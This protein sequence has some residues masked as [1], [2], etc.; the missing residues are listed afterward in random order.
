MP[1]TLPVPEA[2][3]LWPE[4]AIGH[5]YQRT[6]VNL[7]DDGLPSKR[8]SRQ[9]GASSSIAHMRQPLA[10][11]Q[12]DKLVQIT[13]SRLIT[14]A[15]ASVYD[16]QISEADVRDVLSRGWLRNAAY[17]FQ[18]RGKLPSAG[19]VWTPANYRFAAYAQLTRLVYEALP[20]DE[21]QQLMGVRLS[22]DDEGVVTSTVRSAFEE[23]G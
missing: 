5:N 8:S 15:L 14:E 22:W 12:D 11:V 16:V 19:K 13:S 4:D 1:D 7:A 9:G 6:D 21:M 10:E 23:R 18:T 2:S 3:A 20:E 17:P